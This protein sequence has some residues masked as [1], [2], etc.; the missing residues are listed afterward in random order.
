MKKSISNLLNTNTNYSREET[1]T[2]LDYSV[3]HLEELAKEKD[4]PAFLPTDDEVRYSVDA[5]LDY[6][7]Q[8]C[9]LRDM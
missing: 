2:Y 6:E 1:A 7:H 4:G 9:H 3:S 8:Q 5:I